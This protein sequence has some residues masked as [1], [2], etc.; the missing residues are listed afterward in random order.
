MLEGQWALERAMFQPTFPGIRE[1]ERTTLNL[2][3]RSSEHLTVPERDKRDH[4]REDASQRHN[5]IYFS[6]F[7]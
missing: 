5:K 2:S 6:T 1:S 7:T 4:R 3:A